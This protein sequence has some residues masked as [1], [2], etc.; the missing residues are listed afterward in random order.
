MNG[1]RLKENRHIA[2]CDKLEYWNQAAFVA[3]VLN[4]VAGFWIISKPV[5]EVI[6]VSLYLRS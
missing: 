4:F 6:A 2:S 5:D 3:E 1:S